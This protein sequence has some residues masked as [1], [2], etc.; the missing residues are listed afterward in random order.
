MSYKLLLADDS[1]TIQKIVELVLAPENFEIMTFNDGEQ[2]LMEIES[3]MPDIILADIEM[4]KL[5][6]YQLCEKVKN[7]KATADIPVILLAGAFEPFDEE[8][9]GSVMADG[10]II[11]PFGSQELISKV[12]ALLE[13]SRTLKNAPVFT[14]HGED[15]RLEKEMPA[16]V[17]K[18]GEQVLADEYHE[19][20][21]AVFSGTEEYGETTEK[22]LEGSESSPSGTEELKEK[23]P[24]ITGKDLGKK[25]YIEINS[26]II[27]SA[28]KESIERAITAE[29]LTIIEQTVRESIA[30]LIESM[31][32]ETNRAIR[33]IVPEIAEMLI[34]KE[35][36]KITSEMQ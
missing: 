7:N 22:I 30:E 23:E 5:N 6:G 2:A 8:Y 19:V 9:A 27:S 18:S 21:A 32:G 10:S 1:L 20:K 35:I 15:K 25:F 13:G 29:T 12:K 24:D 26:D 31:R 4:P 3:F 17:D 28:I 34:K 36:E 14:A 33:K 16:A 11:K